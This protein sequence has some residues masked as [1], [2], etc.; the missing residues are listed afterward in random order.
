MILFKSP[1]Q[2]IITPAIG[3]VKENGGIYFNISWLWF[4]LSFRVLTMIDQK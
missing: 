2:F 1:D 3:L 4:G